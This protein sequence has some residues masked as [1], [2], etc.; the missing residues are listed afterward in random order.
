M[1]ERQPIHGQTNRRRLKVLSV[2]L[3]I[4]FAVGAVVAWAGIT[5]LSPAKDVL[6][7]SAFTTVEVA[8]GEVG[9]SINL[10]A[11]AEWSVEPIGK[12][13]AVGVVT[14]VDAA[15]GAELGQGAPLY[16]VNLR[17]VVIARGA[18]PAFRSIGDG[19]TGVDVAQLQTM[20]HDL[21]FYQGTVDGDAG[22]RTV[23]AIRDWQAGLGLEKSGVVNLGDVIFVPTLP[24]RVLLDTEIISRGA[25]VGGGEVVV[26]G[27]PA[28]PEFSLPVTASQATA[29]PSGTRVEVTGPDDSGT[30]NGYVVDQAQEPGTDTVIVSLS[31]PDGSTVCGEQCGSVPIAGE[32]LLSARIVTAE[33]VAGLVVPSAA[34]VTSP[35]GTVGVVTTGGK[36]IPVTQLAAAKGMSVVDGVDEGTRVRVPSS[37]RAK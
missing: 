12:N 21:G 30:W 31:G 29:M 6:E 1:V 18:V 10:N 17:P 8:P 34:L 23:A 20:L 36:T 32:S 2:G 22:A 5:V 35:S 27:L 28:S 37:T 7:S 11:V 26:H 15:E 9:S 25:S 33:I 13:Q 14:T 19:T 16:S 3:V 24:A 4:A